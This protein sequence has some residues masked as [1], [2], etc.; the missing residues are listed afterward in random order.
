[1]DKEPD[2]IR[3]EIEQT[4]SNLTEKLETLESQVK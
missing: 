4:R 1:M 3:Q 2:V